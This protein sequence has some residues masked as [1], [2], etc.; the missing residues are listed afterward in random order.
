MNTL[1][2]SSPNKPISGIVCRLQKIRRQNNLGIQFDS[3][4]KRFPTKINQHSGESSAPIST[5]GSY[6]KQ[7]K[8]FSIKEFTFSATTSRLM[9]QRSGRCHWCQ[10]THMGKYQ[11]LSINT[12]FCRDPGLLQLSE[13]EYLL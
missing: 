7:Q 12:D 11:T 6:A 4:Q 5:M 10:N 3:E 9:V 13:M 1:F 8:S 2:V